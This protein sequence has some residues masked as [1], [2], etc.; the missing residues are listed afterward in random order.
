MCSTQSQ[1]SGAILRYY[2]VSDCSVAR[3]WTAGLNLQLPTVRAI[4][5]SDVAHVMVLCVDAY[6][7]W[8]RSFGQMWLPITSISREREVFLSS[9]AFVCCTHKSAAEGDPQKH[10]DTILRL[11]YCYKAKIDGVRGW[12]ARRCSSASYPLEKHNIENNSL[13]ICGP[14]SVNTQFGIPYK[15]IRLS[16]NIATRCVDVILP[17]RIVRVIFE[18]QSVTNNHV[19]FLLKLFSVMGEK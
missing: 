2:R 13:T 1:I 8:G 14:L 5:E 11:E 6:H 9:Y 16:G 19:F 7:L 18:Q 4:L 12:Q 3:P 15:R 17:L 10:N